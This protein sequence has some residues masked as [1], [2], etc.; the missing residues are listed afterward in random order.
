MNAHEHFREAERLQKRAH[1]WHDYSIEGNQALSPLQRDDR[2]DTDIA[3]ALI[4]AMLAAAA[5][6][7]ADTDPDGQTDGK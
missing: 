3:N 4:H 6:L 2:R 7:G 1:T 5:A